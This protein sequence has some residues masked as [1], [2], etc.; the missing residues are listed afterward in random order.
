MNPNPNLALRTQNSNRDQL[1]PHWRRGHCPEARRGGAAGCAGQLAGGGQP[2]AS[3]SWRKRL[4][5]ELGAERWHARWEDLVADPG[6]D[7]VYVATPVHVHAAQAIA[8][9][10]AGKHV[11]CEKPMA[12]DVAE[13]DRMIAA[14]RA[15]QVRLG[16]AYYRHFY[17]AVVRLRALVDAGEIGDPVLAQIDA[18]ER[19]NP[20]RTKSGTG[21]SSV[22]FPAAARCSTSAATASKSS[23]RC[24]VRFGETVGLTANVVFDREVEDT[25][26][27]AL[28]VRER[29]VRDGDRHPRGDRAQ[30]HAAHLRDDGL[31]SHCRAERRTARRHTGRPGAAR[32]A[33]AGSNL[34]Q[35]L[36]EDFVDAVR[37]DRAPAVDGTVGRAVAEI[38]ASA[39][40]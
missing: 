10:E 28:L 32:V 3:R 37:S 7:A 29:A 23:C 15:N 1:G 22:R 35:P 33:P 40:V 9:A 24:S 25:A 6:I 31:H 34:H 20:R 26:V 12:M 39:H 8:A 19:F 14:C 18:F 16:V 27:A 2:R 36:V 4:R 5:R 38:E 30:G 13:C 21:S 17:P 11:L